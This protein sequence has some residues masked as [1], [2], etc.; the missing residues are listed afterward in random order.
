MKLFHRRQRHMPSAERG[1]RL[2]KAEERIG[3]LEA[4]RDGLKVDLAAAKS[5]IERQANERD[6]LVEAVEEVTQYAKRHEAERDALAEKLERAVEALMFLR[7]NYDVAD[8]VD[9][10]IAAIQETDR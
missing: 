8:V 10:T 9:T 4:E 6:A 7:A 3:A 1:Y 2:I 5:F